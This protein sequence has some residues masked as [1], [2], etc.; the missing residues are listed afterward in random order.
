MVQLVVVTAERMHK[1]CECLDFEK[2]V[3]TWG[4]WHLVGLVEQETKVGGAPGEDEL[5]PFAISAEMGIRYRH[6]TYTVV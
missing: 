4:I 5:F 6:I 2:A 3:D 1:E